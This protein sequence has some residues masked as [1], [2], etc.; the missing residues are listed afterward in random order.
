MS[1]ILQ[2]TQL[3]DSEDVFSVQIWTTVPTNFLGLD[4]I[5]KEMGTENLLQCPGGHLSLLNCHTM[6]AKRVKNALPD[7]MLVLHIPLV[8]KVYPIN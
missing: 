5:R 3:K 1:T 4:G 7:S 8:L 2:A 6:Y